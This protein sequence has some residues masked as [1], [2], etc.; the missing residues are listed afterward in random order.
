ME[1]MSYETKRIEGKQRHLFGNAQL[2]DTLFNFVT[3]NMD[4]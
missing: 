2:E 4:I 1:R 3:W